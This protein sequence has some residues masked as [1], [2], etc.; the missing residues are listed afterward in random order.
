MAEHGDRFVLDPPRAAGATTVAPGWRLDP[1]EAFGRVAPLVVEI[2]AGNGGQAVHAAATYPATNYLAVEVW[3]PGIAQ[4]VVAAARERTEN[5]RVLPADAAASLGRVLPAGSVA[6]VWTFFPDPWR[7]ARHHKRRL[8]Q[9]GFAADVARI[10]AP[11]GVWRLATDWADYAEHMRDV[12]DSSPYFT[13][14][15][16]ADAHGWSPRYVGRVMT[17]FE[18]K[19]I[20]A[21]RTVRD[22][23]YVRALGPVP[24]EAGAER[25]VPADGGAG[26]SAPDAAAADGAGPD[27]A[28]GDPE[29]SRG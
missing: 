10:L 4:A 29:E 7:K 17:L 6:E 26:H 2:G 28:G 1:A 25:P 24:D 14:H 5:L 12:L 27:S 16:D 18:R 23:A 22:L 11:G 20:R 15:E 21:G 8:V 9:P 19:G 3:V 13:R